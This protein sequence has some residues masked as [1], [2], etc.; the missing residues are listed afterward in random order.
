MQLL[1]K[2]CHWGRDSNLYPNIP[3]TES[4]P[5]PEIIIKNKKYICFS[6]NNYLGLATDDRIKR[7]AKLAIDEY[8]IGTCESRNMA[9]NLSLLNKLEACISKFKHTEDSVIFATGYLANLGAIYALIKAEIV[10][11]N[12]GYQPDNQLETIIFSDEFNHISIFHAINA[13]GARSIIYKHIDVNDLETKLKMHYGKRL[14]VVTDGVFSQDGEI[15]PVR[16]I[17]EIAEKYNA[18]VYIDDAHATGIL[19][20]NGRGTL[21]YWGVEEKN[22]II[23]G[24]LS[25]AVGAMGGFVATDREIVEIIKLTSPPYG[26]TSSLPPEQAAAIIQ[27]LKIIENEPERREKLWE[28]T[29]YF[30]E[31]LS[32]MGFNL[33]SKQTP[34]IPILI[35]DEDKCIRFAEELLNDGIM[36]TPVMF[37]AVK[38]GKSRIRCQINCTH[39]FQHM[40]LALDK[41][42]SVGKKLRII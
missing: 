1:K 2:L 42:E 37:P 18:V 40:D 10:A 17:I 27:S 33:I 35:G 38:I 12:Y 24:T 19:G 6:S 25:K 4:L 7:A 13:A 22:C 41:F 11:R 28:N 9:G 39:T 23:M 36:V 5:N 16:D 15:A 32:N 30:Q 34:I 3:E 21:E 26:F 31:K 29:I 8:G 20:K 14:F